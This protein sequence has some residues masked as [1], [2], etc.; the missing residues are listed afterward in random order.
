MTSTTSLDGRGSVIASGSTIQQAPAPSA[1]AAVRQQRAGAIAAQLPPL[2]VSNWNSKIISR[3]SAVY[4]PTR[5]SEIMDIMKREKHVRV[6]GGMHSF[7][8]G[9]SAEG[10][11]F[12]NMASF[13]EVG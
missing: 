10:V 7:N 8:G 11:A 4:M 5:E 12:I 9:L 6:G 13:N 3:P 1:V 2:P